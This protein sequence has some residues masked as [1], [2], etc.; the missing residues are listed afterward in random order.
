MGFSISSLLVSTV[1][2]NEARLLSCVAGLPRCIGVPDLASGKAWGCNLVNITTV[3]GGSE[4]VSVGPSPQQVQVA[5][6]GQNMTN[7]T[8]RDGTPVTFSLPVAM[9]S[10]KAEYFQWVMS[11]G[12]SRTAEC[13]IPNGGPANE[14]N[15][16]ETIAIIG[17][18]GGWGD[19]SLVAMEIVGPLMLIASNGS[20][21]SAE[22]LRYD[23]PSLVWENGATLLSARL[24][25][26]STVGEGVVN[27][28]GAYPN[29]CRQLFPST[30]H[31]VRLLWNGGVSLDGQRP[32]TPDRTDLF[33]LKDG[34]AALAAVAV[35]GLAD[36]G[37]LPAPPPEALHERDTYASDGDNYLDV[38][39]SL[40]GVAPPTVVEVVCGPG[41]QISLPKGLDSPHGGYVPRAPALCVPHAVNVSEGAP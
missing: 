7:F 23:G 33:V 16:Q 28:L 13:A 25:E 34:D 5:C 39:L 32:I 26:F 12:T 22:G 14:G 30:T 17:D 18:A 3:D 24:E 8:A 20:R 9:D 21:V 29:H 4:V 27:P 35:L 41:T 40:D 37:K 38:C 6:S 11:D 36:L 19:V 10:V 15:E 31:R 2:A 1:A